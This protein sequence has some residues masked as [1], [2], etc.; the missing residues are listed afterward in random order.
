[1][2]MMICMRANII[3]MSLSNQ[4]QIREKKSSGSK[5][6]VEK[7]KRSVVGSDEIKY[8]TLEKEKKHTDA[9]KFLLT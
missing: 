6:Q 7:T 5:K 1:M 3:V 9:I 4:R 2:M 8:Y